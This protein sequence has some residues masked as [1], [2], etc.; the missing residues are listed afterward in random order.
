[1]IAWYIATTAHTRAGFYQNLPSPISPALPGAYHLFGAGRLTYWRNFLVYHTDNYDIM[2][3]GP[4]VTTPPIDQPLASLLFDNPGAVITL[5]SQDSYHFRVSKI[6]IVN[7]SPILSKLIRSTLDSPSNANPETSTP[8]LQ[9]QDR[10]ETL[11]YLLTFIFPVTPLL[12]STLE[13][14]ME[15]LSVAQKYQMVTTLAH[16]RGSIARHNSLPTDLEPA[17]HTYALAQ[18]YGLLPEALQAARTILLKQSMTIEDFEN[19]LDI[20]SGASLYELWK[21]YERVRAILASDLAD[22]RKSCARGT[23]TGLRCTELSSSQIPIWLDQY[24]ESVEKSPNLFDYA[25]FNI[26]LACHIKDKN[27]ELGCQCASI[28]S[29]TMRNFWE[30]LSFVVNGCFEKVS[31]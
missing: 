4:L 3:T 11:H 14:I 21:Y 5:C 16:L 6:Y 24:I 10:G 28:P 22:F 29:Q 18:K 23:I 2:S 17:L 31:S 30:A 20:M 19:K 15:L 12:P 7:S 8:V 9:L 25:E 26:A 13:E 1:M 27:N